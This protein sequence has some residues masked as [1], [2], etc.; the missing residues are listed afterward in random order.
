VTPGPLARA[1]K[2]KPEPRAVRIVER[3]AI[4]IASLALSFGLIAL[5]SGFFAGRDQPGVSGTTG[6]GT[7]YVDLGH[8]LLRPGE[9]V[10]YDSI[11]PTSGAHIPKP[12]T[13]NGA[14]LDD[15]ELLSALQAGNVVLMYG[16]PQPPA[17][18][19]QLARSLAA[20]FSPGLAASGQA[21]I[22]AT[23]PGTNGIIGLAW[24]HEV[25]VRTASD[26]LLRQFTSF[27]LG[28]GA[29]N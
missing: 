2:E 18:L 14:A 21:V 3:I 23:R 22:L 10:G 25:R 7:A 24:T 9:R 6:P 12:V 16:S 29:P 13:R 15:D 11:P 19:A 28:R 1:R 17:G 26:P 4:V 20:P 8:A 27:W 5:A